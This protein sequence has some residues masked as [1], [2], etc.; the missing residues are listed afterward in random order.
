MGH[1]AF[2]GVGL[3]R[4]DRLVALLRHEGRDADPVVRQRFADLVIHLRVALYNQRRMQ[5]RVKAGGTPGPELSMNKLA[6]SRN[7]QRLGDFAAS[8]LGPKVVAD[9]GEWGTY[10]WSQFI[11]GIPGMRIAGGSDEVIRNIVGERVLGLPKDAGID[12]VSAFKD[13][14]K[15]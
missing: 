7:L 4:L 8:V 15:N 11:L 3:L 5:A 9:T 10:A 6:L 12:S 1:S 14:P 13:L 2:A